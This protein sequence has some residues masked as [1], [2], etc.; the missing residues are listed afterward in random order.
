MCVT[1]TDTHRVCFASRSESESGVPA[2][3]TIEGSLPECW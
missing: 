3:L 2:A 1:Y